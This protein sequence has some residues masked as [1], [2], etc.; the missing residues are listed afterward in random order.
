MR[1]DHKQSQCFKNWN[2]GYIWLQYVIFLTSDCLPAL[3]SLFWSL[4]LQNYDV[5]LF[6]LLS[7][8]DHLCVRLK[9]FSWSVWFMKGVIESLKLAEKWSLT[10]LKYNCQ[11]FRDKIQAQILNYVTI[12]LNTCFQNWNISRSVIWHTYVLH[13]FYINIFLLKFCNLGQRNKKFLE[14]SLL[15]R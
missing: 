15:F 9:L 2:L 7:C 10:I 1:H 13:Y 8:I 12:K 4:Q 6:H 5:W 14:H 3:T 11:L